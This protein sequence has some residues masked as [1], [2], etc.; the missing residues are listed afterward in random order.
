MAGVP[1]ATGFSGSYLKQFSEGTFQAQ[2]IVNLMKVH[3]SLD[4]FRDSL[5]AVISVPLQSELPVGLTPEIIT[6]GRSKYEAILQGIPRQVL[7]VA[8]SKISQAR[9]F[10]CIGYGFNDTQVQENILTQIRRGIPIVVLTKKV[11]DH[12]AHL[13]ANNAKQYISI[14]E[15]RKPNTTEIC[16]NKVVETIDGTLWTIDGFMSIID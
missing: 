15:G 4:V 14:Q 16:I 6:P 12:A 13:L 8:D 1:V 3:G 2:N 7:S 9:G 5:N 11:F 10:L